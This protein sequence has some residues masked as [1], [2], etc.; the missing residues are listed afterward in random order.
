MARDAMAVLQQQ[1]RAPIQHLARTADDKNTAAMFLSAR[2]AHVA[3]DA[4]MARRCGVRSPLFSHMATPFVSTA[5]LK[6]VPLPIT[7]LSMLPMGTWRGVPVMR[8]GWPAARCPLPSD[9]GAWSALW[10]AAPTPMRTT[11]GVLWLAGANLRACRRPHLRCCACLPLPTDAPAMLLV[12]VKQ[13]PAQPL[14]CMPHGSSP[15][16]VFVVRG[17]SATRGAEP[18]SHAHLVHL[19]KKKR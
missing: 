16:F 17:V 12:L 3:A 19:D 7:N 5:A 4:L 13:F 2:R 1:R 8:G 18:R 11:R 15:S 9:C 10:L 14:L 6:C